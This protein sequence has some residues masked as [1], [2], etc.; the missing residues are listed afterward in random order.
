MVFLEASNSENSNQ[1]N[2]S[3]LYLSHGYVLLP[4]AILSYLQ[5]FF[6]WPGNS[7]GRQGIIP[8]ENGSSVE[9][10]AQ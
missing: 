4:G 7:Q 9:H 5:M 1:V 8:A 6:L 3:A 2:S 10:P